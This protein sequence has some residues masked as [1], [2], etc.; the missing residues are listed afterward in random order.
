MIAGTDISGDFATV[1]D[2]I[3]NM[4]KTNKHY[5]YILQMLTKKI[6]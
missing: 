1:E 4:P 6:H 5:F 2:V 3:N